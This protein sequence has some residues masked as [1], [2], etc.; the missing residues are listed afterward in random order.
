MEKGI[1]SD[2]TLMEALTLYEIRYYKVS[3]KFSE[4]L[5]IIL[6]FRDSKDFTMDLFKEFKFI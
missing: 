2:K 1:W 5:S 6:T 3:L 4:I